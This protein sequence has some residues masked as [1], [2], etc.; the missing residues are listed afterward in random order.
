MIRVQQ[1]CG[2]VLTYKQMPSHLFTHCMWRFCRSTAGFDLFFILLLVTFR[3]RCAVPDAWRLGQPKMSLL[4][5]LD[6]GDNI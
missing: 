1:W 3:T 6:V 4:L 5:W 2:I